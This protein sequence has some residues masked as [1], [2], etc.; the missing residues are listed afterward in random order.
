MAVRINPCHG[1]PLGK[2]CE[3]RAD[4]R[5]RVS[6]LGLRSATFRCQKIA[7][8]LRPGRRIM[9]SAPVL[10]DRSDGWHPEMCIQ[11]MAVKATITSSDDAG[12]FVCVIDPGQAEDD[13]V[14]NDSKKNIDPNKFRFRRKMGAYRVIRFLDEPDAKL[15]E[16]GRRILRGDACDRPPGETCYCDQMDQIAKEFPEEIFADVGAMQNGRAPS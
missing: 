13:P 10:E 1:C 4:F 9:I 11:H 2:D 12:R 6:G 8:A 14:P 15:C 3:Q 7:D 5:A 16:E